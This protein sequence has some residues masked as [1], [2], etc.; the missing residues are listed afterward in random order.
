[1]TPETAPAPEHQP[2]PRRPHVAWYIALGL[3]LAGNVALLFQNRSLSRS[4]TDF[5]SRTQAQVNA[6]TDHMA[7][8]SAA[9]DRR[10]EGV[11]QEARDTTATAQA[12]ALSDARKSQAALSARLA[13]SRRAQRRVAGELDELKQAHDATA[14]K[15]NE[16]GGDLSGV[17]GDVAATKS[18]V[19][20]HGTELK[21]VAGDMG[22]M[23]G[24]IATNAKE[25]AAL[26]ELGERN[27]VEFD[28]KRKSQPQKVGGIQLSL[29]KADAK[30][31][32]FT[33]AVL[34]DD[35]RVEKRDRTINEPVQ[36]YLS[37]NRQP[38][39]IVVNEVKKDEVVGYLA[40]PKVTAPR[41]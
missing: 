20:G 6:L 17:K 12:R 16:I 14:S 26:R 8:Y 1:M 21:R 37:G 28:L 2:T 23:G 40:S 22:V 15:V 19:D 27:Y 33:L 18:Q 3:A 24:Q 4:M 32:R 7:Q 36:L 35:K 31:S 39:E 38:I 13:E 29:L 25:L 30:R 10:V 5:Q 34:A 11:A 9:N 41:R